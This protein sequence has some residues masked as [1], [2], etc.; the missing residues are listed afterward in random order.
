[1]GTMG[2][3]ATSSPLLTRDPGP[4]QAPA[5]HC[6]G[7]WEPRL[8]TGDS[9]PLKLCLSFGGLPSPVPHLPGDLP[10]IYPGAFSNLFSPS[11]ATLQ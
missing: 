10:H 11:L 5:L 8:R 1:M 6:W 9:S 7:A 3:A 4:G 2:G